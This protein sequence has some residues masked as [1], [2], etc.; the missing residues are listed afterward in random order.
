MYEMRS[1]LRRRLCLKAC[2]LCY[3]S[4]KRRGLSAVQWEYEVLIERQPLLVWEA[5]GAAC[6][7]LS[8]AIAAV[9]MVILIRTPEVLVPFLDTVDPEHLKYYTERL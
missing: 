6:P 2:I 8:F 4:S 1:S 9:T 5:D 3:L 7:F